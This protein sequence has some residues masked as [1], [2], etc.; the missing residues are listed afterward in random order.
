MSNPSKT[1]IEYGD[2][3][4]P[5]SLARQ[6]GQKLVKLGISPDLIIEPTC[7]IGNFIEIATQNFPS[8]RK[9]IGLEINV[10]HLKLLETR[11]KLWERSENI[12]L[13]QGDFFHFNWE[14]ILENQGSLLILGNFPW[15]TN[16]Q[17]S[18]INST[19][20]PIKSN[21]SNDSGIKAL[22]G[23]SN[24]DISEWMLL[25]TTSWL[26]NRHGYIAMLCK[27]SV[28]RK[29]LAHLHAKRIGIQQ[30]M[31]YQIDAKRYFNACVDACLLFC[32]FKPH[33]YHYDYLVYQS[34]ESEQ[35]QNIG[36][37][38]G[39]VVR[40]LKKFEQLSQYDGHSKVSWRSGIKH[41]CSNILELRKKDNHYFNKLG[42]IVDVE[43]KYLYP[44]L[45]G[46]DIANGRTKHT[47]RYILVTQR[48]VGDITDSIQKDA[49]KTWKYLE[50]HES[51]FNARKSRIYHYRSR[52]SIFGVGNYSF[53][54]YKIAIC[55]LYKKLA[56]RLIQP[57][58]Q[59]PVVFDDT[60][61]FLS[62]DDEAEAILIFEILTSQNTLDF[63]SSLIFWDEK[64]P[65][66]SNILNRFDP[67]Q[68][69]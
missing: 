33:I 26:E 43:P 42:E 21:F 10:E 22:T 34:L 55:G 62:F 28:A 23:K 41:D 57:I 3:Q 17:Q 19:N 59:K 58:E 66:K 47:E 52:F 51:Y 32:E 9:I 38:N 61:Y 46:S 63:Y 65:I 36:Y 29:F 25:Q 6:V 60:V 31:L 67:Y 2:F 5:L 64:R 54:P 53:T 39:R 49:P 45:K 68:F 18:R 11:K 27:T 12:E 30:A 40:D 4:T 7:G 44:L 20:L 8:T 16:S 1:K 35:T 48:E 56:F 50:A 13:I 15:V 69:G 37:R 14:K 24:F